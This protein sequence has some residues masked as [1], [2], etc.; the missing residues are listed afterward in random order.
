[1]KLYKL[2]KL[3]QKRQFVAGRFLVGIDPAKAKHEAQI[4]DTD[5]LPV[6]SSF[7]FVTSYSGFNE[8]LWRQLQSRLPAT[9]AELPRQKLIDHLVFAVEA[10]CNLW[11]TLVDYLEVQ[12]GRVV[13]VSPLATC[14]ARPA[15][16]GD[17]SRTDTK[18]AF[19][20]A[21]LARQGTFQFR[22]G[23][24]S[25]QE[26]MHRLAITYDK[27]RKDLQRCRARLRAQVEVLFP[28]FAKLL[29]LNSLTARHLLGRYLTPDDFLGLD[30]QRETAALMLLSR[31]QHGRRTLLELQA[32][33]R[34]SIGVRLQPAERTAQRVTMDSWLV[35]IEALE[36][37]ISRV[38]EELIE[39]A[40]ATPYYASIASLKGVSDLLAALFIAELRD[41]SRYP[42]P[43][44]IER[45]AGYTLH[46]CD[47]GKY[48]GRRRITHLGNARLRWIL[49]LMAS[50]T[51]KY[52]PEIRGKYLRRRLA[53]HTN[54]QKNL[55]AVIPQ[56]LA[57]LIAL[58]RDGRRYEE[59]PEMVAEAE[60]LEAVLERRKKQRRQ[61]LGRN[62][63]AA[64]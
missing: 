58:M 13:M 60:R 33:A 42:R 34:H 59:R 6:G 1:M 15:K 26:A 22:E 50:E 16:S 29:K 52:V 56:L 39:W 43:K 49:Y 40:R 23:Y 30:L 51:S 48:R 46:V 53:G 61:S 54:R 21:D 11:P 37:E 45:M 24:T 5:G 63:D 47:S 20:I 28:E 7:S 3:Q 19:L 18:D 41:P 25:E 2:Q 12:H 36:T 32:L 14:H 44:Q 62:R 35:M 4:L 8:R 17:F 10:S 57:L 64:A 31:D 55:V 9:L 38:S 27:L